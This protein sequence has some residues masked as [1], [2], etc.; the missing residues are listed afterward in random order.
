MVESGSRF[1]TPPIVSAH[2]SFNREQWW[3]APT[4]AHPGEESPAAVAAAV[5]SR[6]SAYRSA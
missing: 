4:T 3:E 2:D 1:A 5:A 6:S